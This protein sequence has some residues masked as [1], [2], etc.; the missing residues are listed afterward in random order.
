MRFLIAVTLVVSLLAG[1]S[2]A[3]T[4]G[5]ETQKVKTE[6]TEKVIKTLLKPLSTRG[7]EVKSVRPVGEVKVPGFET[8]EVDLVDKRNYR[9]LKR[10]IFVNPEKKLIAL[11]IFSYSLKGDRVILKPLKPNISE[12][13]LKTDV[14]FL[15]KVEN[16]LSENK[17]PHVVGKGEG[18]VYVVWDVFCPFCY[19]HFN[20]IEDIAKKNNVEIHMIPLA[21]HG[22][23]SLKGLIYYTKLARE[24]GVAGALKELY[25]L[26]NGDFMRFAKNLE[27]KINSTKEIVKDQQKV[28]EALKKV[29]ELLV[30]H[31]I[32]ATPTL[33]Y[34]P[35]GEKQGYVHVG[36]I[37]IEKLVKENGR[38]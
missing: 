32:R 36:F 37:P 14:S 27:K 12:K 10:Y 34:V 31:N 23:N 24:K 19:K 4:S 17:I 2:Q 25:S 20:Q 1:C 5:E 33:I 26:G 6:Q 11:Q 7:V 22:D 16:I 13:K 3:K 28:I 35:P 8:F 30:K 38:N 21:V 18:K 9:E 29:E 15:K